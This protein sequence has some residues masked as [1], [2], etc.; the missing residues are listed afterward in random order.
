MKK[1]VSVFVTFVAIMIM[2]IFFSTNVTKENKESEEKVSVIA[3][4]FP[5]YD[6]AKQIGKEKVDVTL[7]LPP[8]TETHTYYPSPKDI[9]VPICTLLAGLTKHFQL[10]PSIFFKSNI[11][12]V[13]FV[14][15]FIPISLA[16]KTLVSF[17]T[18][19]SPEFK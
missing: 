14:S 3:T 9:I 18:K 15:S 17:N 1:I 12:I 10:S 2:I 13:A 8:G 19:T 11:S 16:G 6:F 7:L 4:L 5:Q